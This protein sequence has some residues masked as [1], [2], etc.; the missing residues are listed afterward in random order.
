M[1][2]RADTSQTM[3]QEKF[4]KCKMCE[5]DK[6]FYKLQCENPLTG[7]CE[8]FVDSK[9]QKTQARKLERENQS[10]LEY[11]EF[12][13]N[14]LMQDVEDASEDDSTYIEPEET[15]TKKMKYEY[16]EDVD[17]DND[18]LPYKFRHI[19]TKKQRSV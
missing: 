15:T 8:K 6:T 7:Y 11:Y 17:N 2:V 5:L 14:N 19:R 9:W 1:D 12:V 18:E 16:E 3:K 4:W 10:R 13:H